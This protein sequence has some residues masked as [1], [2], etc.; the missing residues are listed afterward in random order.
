MEKKEGGGRHYLL[1]QMIDGE[2]GKWAR[3]KS[4]M[5]SYEGQEGNI[6]FGS[7]E[8]RFKEELEKKWPGVS[9]AFLVCEKWERI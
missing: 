5:V 6:K 3:D 8:Q 9:L 4:I 1:L 2:L 7:L